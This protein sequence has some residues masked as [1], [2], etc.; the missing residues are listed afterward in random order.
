MH[1][2]HSAEMLCCLQVHQHSAR[3]VSI[4][5]LPSSTHLIP[6]QVFVMDTCFTVNDLQCSCVHAD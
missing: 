4:L 2:F 5:I 3:L 1:I 6:D